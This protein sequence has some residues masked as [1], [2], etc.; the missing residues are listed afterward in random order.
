LTL[1]IPFTATKAETLSPVC[2]PPCVIG[3]VY[4]QVP[5]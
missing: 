5:H 2:S 3:W 4:P 1:W